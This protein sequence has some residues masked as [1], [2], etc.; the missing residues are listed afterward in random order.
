MHFYKFLFRIV[1]QL[2]FLL[3]LLCWMDSS[4]AVISIY[5][6]GFLSL[7][8][9]VDS[10]AQIIF[11]GRVFYFQQQNVFRN[12]LANWPLL[13]RCIYF[14]G[15]F[16]FGLCMMRVHQLSNSNQEYLTHYKAYIVVFSNIFTVANIY[17]IFS[18]FTHRYNLKLPGQVCYY[19]TI[20][21][22]KKTI[23]FGDFALMVQFEPEIWD[24]G[25]NVRID[26][27]A[28]KI[29]DGMDYQPI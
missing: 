4:L 28:A 18:Q 14:F 13:G 8:E 16:V 7:L 27:P 15:G 24:K 22:Q 23:P 9:F 1:A 25:G 6:Y 3:P 29:R 20:K 17:Y 19:E 21:D 2:S 11:V 12:V 10:A 26:L 5:M